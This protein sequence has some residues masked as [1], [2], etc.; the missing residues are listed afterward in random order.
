MPYVTVPRD[1][2]KVKNKVVLGLTKRQLLSVLA[3]GALCIPLY[4][5]LFTLGEL[6]IYI[7][8]LP[9][10]PCFIFGFYAAKDG[11]PLENVLKCYIDAR[12]RRPRHRPYRTQN[13]YRQ[14]MYMQLIQEVM[15][16]AQQEQAGADIN[17]E[18]DD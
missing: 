5:L 13:A 6:A 1:L 3:A 18:W 15:D 8:V 7:A 2:S 16:D 9:A 10:V 14:L 12:Y 4:L 11:R 17:T